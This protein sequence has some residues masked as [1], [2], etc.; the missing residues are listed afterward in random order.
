MITAAIFHC[1]PGFTWLN[2]EYR[3]TNVPVLELTS[4]EK[5][6]ESS[7]KAKPD[8]EQQPSGKTKLYHIPHTEKLLQ[9]LLLGKQS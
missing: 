1:Q 4:S 2:T 8:C 5:Q 7:L 6:S 9:L 3:A